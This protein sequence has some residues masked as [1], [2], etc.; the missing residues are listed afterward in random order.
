MISAIKRFKTRFNRLFFYVDC[1]SLIKQLLILVVIFA[2]MFGGTKVL[3][4]FVHNRA[5]DPALAASAAPGG[6]NLPTT[7]LEMT[8]ESKDQTLKIS[9]ES[10]TQFVAAD[11]KEVAIT[12]VV[13]AP[14]LEK[15][16]VYDL[17]FKNSYKFNFKV[18]QTLDGDDYLVATSQKTRMTEMPRAATRL[19]Q[20]PSSDVTQ[21]QTFKMVLPAKEYSPDFYPTPIVNGQYGLVTKK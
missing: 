3:M 2:I 17:E 11:Q 10:Q 18:Y 20:F 9:I 7:G 8:D 16:V 6:K 12:F 5:V 4:K 14:V 21:R 1:P 15:P 13:D 19:L